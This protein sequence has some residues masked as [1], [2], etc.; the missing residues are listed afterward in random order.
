MII[1]KLVALLSS[2]SSAHFLVDDHVT[3]SMLFQQGTKP[4]WE[5]FSLVIRN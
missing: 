5:G 4:D 2:L 1:M 3:A